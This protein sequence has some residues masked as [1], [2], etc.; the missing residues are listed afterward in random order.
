MSRLDARVVAEVAKRHLK[1]DV[2]QYQAENNTGRIRQRSTT[3]QRGS[4]DKPGSAEERQSP[5]DLHPD[6]S[7]D[8]ANE[9]I[10]SHCLN[11]TCLRGC[12]SVNCDVNCQA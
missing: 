1:W 10:V 7:T 3:A 2:V 4:S 6:P 5:N 8:L 12:L 11:V 9:T